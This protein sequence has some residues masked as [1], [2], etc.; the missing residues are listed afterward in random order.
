ML[1]KI[2][3]ILHPDRLLQNKVVRLGLVYSISFL[4][5][6]VLAYFV[7]KETYIIA[8]IP[9]GLLVLFIAIYRLEL[10][11]WI[12]L[13]TVP[14]SVPLKEFGLNVDFN[15]FLP[16]EPLLAGLFIIFLIKL[17][18]DGSFDRKVLRHPVTIVILLQLGWI[19][20]TSISSTMPDVSFKFFL[21]RLWFV[22]VFY[23]FATQ[24]FKDTSKIRKYFWF[25][26]IPLAFIV[27]VITIKHAG[28]GLYD[29][30]ASNPAVDPFFNDHT[31]YG[32]I[33][34]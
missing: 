3:H 16:T 7:T 33:M 8:A 28:L 29:Q 6:I 11:F 12:I 13:F 1:S 27:V 32:A 9:I 10:I 14:L 15:M 5:V 23:F 31:L 34:A 20:V 24:V 21:S 22:V 25:I 4:Y 30:K 17:A 18:I 2:A 26:L 19:L